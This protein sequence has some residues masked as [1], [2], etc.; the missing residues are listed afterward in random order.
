MSRFRYTGDNGR[1]GEADSPYFALAIAIG[2]VA[3]DDCEIKW[4]FDDLQEYS[5]Q[6]DVAQV[7]DDSGLIGKLENIS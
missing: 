4:G 7:F 2:R 6:G 3:A 1:T 5:Q